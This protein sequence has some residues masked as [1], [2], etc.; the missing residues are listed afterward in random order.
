MDFVAAGM[1]SALSKLAVYPMETKV[2]LSAVGEHAASD[3]SL[4]WHGA[5]L[6]CVENFIFNGLLWVGKESVRPPPPDPS[7]PEKRP[8]A[9]FWGAFCVSCFVVLLLH[10]LSNVVVGMIA[11]IKNPEH[12]PLTATQATAAI[13]EEHGLGGFFNGWRFSIALRFGSAASI[14]IYDLVRVRCAGMLGRDASN[15]VAGVLGRLC[16]VCVGHP[17]RTMRSRQQQGHSILTSWT[18]SSFLGLWCGIGLMAIADALKIGI[19]FLLIERTRIIFQ[20]SL[21]WLPKMK[22]M[23]LVHCKKE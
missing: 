21:V 2:I 7:Q 19:R 23:D 18:F 14:V 1:V 8:P 11:S 6:K 22:R 10:P 15:F 5:G 12:A 20:W 4:L 9:T 17:F 13:M 3:L 16:D